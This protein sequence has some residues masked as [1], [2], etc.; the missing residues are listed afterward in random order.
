M[1]TVAIISRHAISNYG[2][3]L[4][5][6]ALERTIKDLG[7][8]AKTIDYNRTEEKSWHLCKVDIENSTWKNN[9]LKKSVF[10]G[11]NV[12]NRT[13][14]FY[15]FQGFRRELMDLTDEYCSF[16][17][18]NSNPPVADLY[19]TGSD[20]VWNET[21]HGELDWSYFLDF[22]SDEKRIAYA[23]SF[24]NDTI[25]EEHK[26]RI[27]IALSKYNNIS[28]R[29]SSGQDILADLGLN[30]ELVLDP[31][32]LLE[33]E[34]WNEVIGDMVVPDGKYIL[35]YQIHK[36]E[37]LVEY[38][39]KYAQKIGCKVINISV[40]YT[41]KKRGIEFKCL[42]DYKEVLALFRGAYRIVT[43]SF[44]ATSFSINFNKQFV[45]IL[46]Q[47]SASRIKSFLSLMKLENQVLTDTSDYDLL[48]NLIDYSLVTPL[49][50]ELRQESIQ[51]LKEAIK[52][53]IGE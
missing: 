42:P 9:P 47:V 18:L 51:W 46:P 23:A 35:L 37:K 44:H 21:I 41:Q 13:R 39:K 32:L 28:V 8:C 10:Y 11:V 43:D 1:K 2:S 34:K 6:Y 25:K 27:R 33:Q 15:K 12:L 17:E 45:T 29:E 20:Q 53:S 49:L 19:V 36:N 26:D 22:L 3:L 5:A 14:Q 31:T 4:Q 50:T 48:D 24:G 16:Q 7:Y 40:S 38:A 30:G 52:K